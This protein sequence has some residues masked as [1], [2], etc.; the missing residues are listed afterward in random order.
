MHRYRQAHCGDG[1]P[2]IV[3]HR[4]EQ[5]RRVGLADD[6]DAHALAA[7][8]AAPLLEIAPGML[9]AGKDVADANEAIGPAGDGIAEIAVVT[10]IDTWLHQDGMADLR[11]VHLPQQILS[12]GGTRR[13]RNVGEHGLPGIPTRVVGPDVDMSIDDHTG[14]PSYA[15]MECG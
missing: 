14:Y 8:F 4:C 3:L 13:D 15:V 1:F 12:G 2:E 11:R 6:V 9:R 5:P 10:A 7:S